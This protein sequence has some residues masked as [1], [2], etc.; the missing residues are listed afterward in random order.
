MTVEES[1]GS[2][3][4][5]PANTIK[6]NEA[7]FTV[8]ASGATATISI[9]STGAGAALTA[10]HVGFGNASNLLTGSANFTFTDESGGNGPTVLLTGD[11]PI[12]NIQDDTGGTDYFSELSQ[13][14][15][16]LELRSKSSTGGNVEIFR[17][18]T[19]S[20]SFIEDSAGRVGIGT[21]PD[22]GVEEAPCSRYWHD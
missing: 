20:I 17:T 1:D 22:A 2:V 13:S 21:E 12:I 18:R 8:A 10:T 16:S 3:V 5:R 7:D 11:K 6:F 19:D 14:G 15:V 9:D 4:V